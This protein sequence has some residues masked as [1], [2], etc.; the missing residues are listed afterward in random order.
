MSLSQTALRR[1]P[2]AAG[3]S[4]ALATSFAQAATFNVTTNADAGAGS[5]RQAITDANGSAGPHTIDFSSVSGDTITLGSGLP[6]ISETTE[7]LGSDV[8]LDGGGYACLYASAELS[9]SDIT[10]TNC[11]GTYGGGIYAGGYLTVSDSTISNN[12]AV[13]GGG[14]F[15]TDTL[16]LSGSTVSGNTADVGGGLVV[17]GG[18]AVITD[19]TISGNASTAGPIGGGYIYADYGY[20]ADT[21]S[22]SGSTISGNTAATAGGGLIPAVYN[23]YYD[24]DPTVGLTIENS[25]FSGNSAQQGGGLYVINT[26]FNGTYYGAFEPQISGTTITGNTATGGAGGGFVMYNAGAYSYGY[27]ASPAIGNSIIAGNSATS[28]SGDMES[29]AAIGGT[30][31]NFIDFLDAA[32]QAP[33]SFRKWVI[34]RIEK[35]GLSPDE[36]TNEQVAEFFASKV[37]RA[38]GSGDGVTFNMTYSIVGVA[39]TTGTFSPDAATSGAVGSSPT[40]AALANNGGPTMT[41]MP[42]L[43]GSAVDLIPQGSG[44]C[45]TT[46]TVDQRGAPRPEAPGGACDA[47]AVE[48]ELAGVPQ[49]ESVPTLAQW[50]SILMAL[51]LGLMGWLGLRRTRQSSSH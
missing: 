41:H 22:I 14:I 37:T 35:A 28:G 5:F 8:T 42:G 15:A 39:P 9:V 2:L 18:G 27:P 31:P 13:Q 3:I 23:K 4:L 1:A 29:S 21:I 46:Y 50:S 12:T 44:G 43:A 34:P 19:S 30:A 40:L 45:G 17:V 36:L 20:A 6:Q 25:T 7:L 11:D 10:I 32:S 47:G 38:R 49:I 51:G 24:S 33:E 26:G 16:T 48:N